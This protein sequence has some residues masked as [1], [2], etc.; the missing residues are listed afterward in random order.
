MDPSGQWW[1]GY[2]GWLSPCTNLTPVGGRV[3]CSWPRS[4][5]VTRSTYLAV[6]PR[7]PAGYRM[8]ASDGGVFS[9]GNPPFC[10]S[11]GSMPSTV[12][13]WHR[14]HPDGGGYWWWPP[15]AAYSASATPVLRLDRR[16]QLNQ[17]IVGMAATPTVGGTGW[18]PPTAASSASVTP[19]SSAPPGASTSTSPSS[20]WPPPPT[21]GATGWWPP[22]AASSA[23]ATPLLR[24]YRRHPPQPA[25]RRDGRDPRRPGLLAGGLRRRHLQLR[26]RRVL[27]LHRRHPSTSP[28][29]AW[30]PRP[31]GRGYWLVASDGGIFSFGDAAFFGSTGAIHLNQPIVGMGGP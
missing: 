15:T 9:F 20:G 29:S 1:L 11:T 8:A 25:D 5:S 22:T 19:A 24:L 17:P 23:S 6:P 3:G 13:G 14:R 7:G 12:V 10:G 31:D 2:A 21:A 18:W 26:R 27:R 28:S 16:L 4:P 30:P